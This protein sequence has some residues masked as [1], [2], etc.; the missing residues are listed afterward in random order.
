MKKSAMTTV[1]ASMFFVWILSGW[2][3]AEVCQV[4]PA[5]KIAPNTFQTT[6]DLTGLPAGEVFWKGQAI[7]NGHWQFAE[8]TGNISLVISGDVATVTISNWPEGEY[9]EFSYGRGEWPDGAP[10]WVAPVACGDAQV[11]NGHFK[12]KLGLKPPINF[13]MV[14]AVMAIEKI[15]L[16]NSCRPAGNTGDF[17]IVGVED[18]GGDVYRLYLNFSGLPGQ[19]GFFGESVPNGAW[20]SLPVKKLGKCQVVEIFWPYQAK[21]HFSWYG[22]TAGEKIWADAE[23]SGSKF[24][25]CV[26]GEGNKQFCLDP[27]E[28]IANN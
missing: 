20:S 1:V 6:L 23:N 4:S 9:I 26:D 5:K 22:E 16:L 17:M 28:I 8:D 27:V 10:G 2:A 21:I 24:A 13:K 15:L 19:P 18:I 11:V 12:I 14:G 25:T 3:L 7:P